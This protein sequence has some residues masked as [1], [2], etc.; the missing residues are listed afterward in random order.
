MGRVQG[1]QGPVWHGEAHGWVQDWSGLAHVEGHVG[2]GDEQEVR[3]PFG[4]VS[5][6]F[7]PH[8]QVRTT[9]GSKG[10]V[11]GVIEGG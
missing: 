11:G 7:L 1:G 9:D 6:S 5:R 3:W 8:G 4:S 2:I 10:H